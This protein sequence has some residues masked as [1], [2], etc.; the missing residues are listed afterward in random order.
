MF[1][2]LGIVC[3]NLRCRYHHLE[4]LSAT[5]HAYLK[6]LGHPVSARITC[7]LTITMINKAVEPFIRG[8][9]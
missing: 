7:A 2:T 8:D 6:H 1:W 4:P 3:S 5:S 9:Q